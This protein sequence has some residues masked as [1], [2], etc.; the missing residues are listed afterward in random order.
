MVWE[1]K[2]SG[3]SQWVKRWIRISSGISTEL[4]LSDF[5]S[6]RGLLY[7]SYS[8]VPNLIR[9]IR[10]FPSLWLWLHFSLQ[11]A[12][13]WWH[14]KQFMHDTLHSRNPTMGGWVIQEASHVL[15]KSIRNNLGNSELG[16]V[17]LYPFYL[18]IRQLY[19]VSGEPKHKQN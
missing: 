1:T 4:L 5:K 8:R 2:W 6:H 15:A 7:R 19:K 14:M 13:V 3:I 10:S 9:S 12:W 11:T 18:W 16:L 17:Q